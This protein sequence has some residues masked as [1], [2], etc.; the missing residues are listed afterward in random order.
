MTH[1]IRASIVATLLGIA[2]TGVPLTGPSGAQA[3]I[4]GGVV[5]LGVLTDETGVFA[6]LSGEGSVEAARM[7]VEDFGGT[8]AGKPIEIIHA[9][10]QNKADIGVA[11]ARWWIDVDGVDAIVDVPNSAI[12]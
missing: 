7:A 2:W 3:E 8:V 9:D 10:H 5:K 6:S 1:R 12:V 11:I 4:S